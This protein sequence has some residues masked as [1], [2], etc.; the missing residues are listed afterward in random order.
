MVEGENRSP[1]AAAMLRDLIGADIEALLTLNNASVPH[2]NH[3]ER[4]DLAALLDLAAYARGLFE[5]ERL[6]GALIGLWPG[7]VYASANYRWFN[8]HQSKFF[9]VDRVMIEG[10]SR[11]GGYGRRFYADIERFAH[12]G[13]AEHIA[14][15][16]NSEPPNPISMRFHEALGFRPVGELTSEDRSKS[17]I[18]MMKALATS[19]TAQAE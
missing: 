15:E 17:V 6:A 5:A 14:L 16:V 18:L 19:A 8:Q 9:Y 3:L 13:G 11:K 7:E 1:E 4:D 2:V 10:A 12:E